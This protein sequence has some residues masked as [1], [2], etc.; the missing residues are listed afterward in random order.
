[1]AA[2]TEVIK[3]QFPN[4]AEYSATAYF[5]CLQEMVSSSLL[6]LRN[7]QPSRTNV[8]VL[9]YCW[10]AI[11]SMLDFG[12]IANQEA[13]ILESANFIL[14]SG[15]CSA[16]AIKYA[17]ICLQFVLHSKSEN[18]WNTDPNTD[19][20]LAA[21]LNQI[22]A[23]QQGGKDIVQQQAIKSMCI[24]LQNQKIRKLVKVGATIRNF[25]DAKLLQ[26]M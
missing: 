8:D 22:C 3:I 5:A 24:I 12:V 19:K 25:V 23:N 11:I 16:T 4:Q 18:Q 6:A 20:I 10:S 21:I 26:T 15:K 17:I 1:M 9:A 14:T 2:S 13:K 7:G